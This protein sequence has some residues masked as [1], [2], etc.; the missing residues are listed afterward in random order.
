MGCIL[1]LAEDKKY[2]IL[3]VTGD[4]R[5]ENA[6]EDILKSHALGREYNIDKYLMDMRNSRNVESI[7]ANY[8]I[9]HKEI[10]KIPGFNPYAKVAV[11]IAPNDHSHDFYETVARNS[12]YNFRL[13]TNLDEAVKHLIK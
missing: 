11:L 1:E 5:R 7:S 12:G 9:A 2:I 6:M 3:K 8:G 4:Y 10:K 13:F